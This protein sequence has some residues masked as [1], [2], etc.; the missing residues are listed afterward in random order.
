MDLSVEKTKIKI[1]NIRMT[2][3]SIFVLTLFLSLI[4]IY[5]TSL[6]FVLPMLVIS[7]ICGY[8]HIIVYLSALVLTTYLSY[9]NYMLLLISLTSIILMQIVMH[10]KFVKSKYIALIITL[11]SL[12]FLYIYKY[13]YI[14]VLVILSFTLIH[15]LLCLEVV[16]LFIHNT[17]E[18]Y[19]NK[20]MMILSVMIMLAIISLLEVNQLY[21]MILLRFYLLLSVY[22]LNINRT[23]PTILYVSIILMFINPLLKDEILSLILPFSI[24]FMYKPQNKLICSTLYILSH[25]IL[26]FFIEYDYYYHNF[27]IVVSAALFLFVPTFKRKPKLLSD[28]YKNITSRN[29]LIQRANTFAS[30][31]K[32]LTNIFQE[33][34]RD[35]NVGEFVGYVYED[36]CLHCPSRDLCFYQDGSV[37]RLGKLINKGFKSKYSDEDLK[38]IKSNCISPDKFLN[39]INEYKESYEK[40]KRVNQ[41]NSHLKKDLFYEFSLLSEVFDNFSNSLEETPFGDDQLKEHLLGYQFNITYLYK[42][43]ISLD[44]YTLEIG[45]MDISGN[46]VVNELVPIIENYLNESLEVI[47]IQDSMHHLGYT[48]IVLKHQQNYSLQFGIQQYSL[49]PLNCGDSFSAFHQDNLHYLALSDGMGQGKMAATESKLTLEVLSKLILNGI[50]L[51]DTIDSINALLKIKNRNDMFTTLDLCNINLANAK[52]KLI[53]YGANPSYHIRNGIVEKIATNS[54]PVGIVSKL[55]MSSYEMLLNNNDLIIMSSDGTGER[56]EQIINKNI[57][58]F[59]RLHPQEI[60]TLLMNQVLEENNL[61]DISIVVIKIVKAVEDLN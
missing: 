36:V 48:S 9:E 2:Y 31:F 14:E 28:D 55:K 13:N 58:L 11:V 39:G 46:E 10:F 61:D 56:F 25:L 44:V 52:M 57:K 41:E 8:R 32:Q 23:M 30:L 35:V 19:T 37:S 7:F 22:Y 43:Q 4:Q 59:N 15:S 3:I 51:K 21:M 40:I 34:N 17:I 18:V 12:I 27:I 24:F 16:P 50:S 33:A 47:S 1:K 60:S 53:K 6:C 5:D 26:P 54:L 49:E 42:H 38:Y 45:L 29:K 20:R